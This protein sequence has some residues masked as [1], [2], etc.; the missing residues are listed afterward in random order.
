M[1]K[2]SIGFY[3]CS[4]CG[5]CQVSLLEMGNIFTDAAQ[6]AD[7]VLQ[8]LETGNDGVS[9]DSDIVDYL[10]I[11]GSIR[12]TRDREMVRMLRQKA[13]TIIAYG[14]CSSLGGLF[15][16]GNLYS[17]EELLETAYTAKST[18]AGVI[19]HG[20]SDLEDGIL[21]LPELLPYVVPL[22][23]VIAVDYILPGCPPLPNQMAKALPAIF[24]GTAG[25]KD[26]ISQ[27]SV[28]D[29]CPLERKGKKI[30]KLKPIHE[31]TLDP[32]RCL[33]EQGVL[34][35]GP[36]TAGMCE[37]VCPKAGYPCVGCNGPVRGVADQG[38]RMVTALASVITA[39]EEEQIGEAEIQE[40]MASVLDPT[41]T[42]YRF[43][44]PSSMLQYRRGE[45]N[46]R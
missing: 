31:V 9:S 3:S 41:G 45:Y 39:G 24:N 25:K 13:E 8:P 30:E 11:S 26:F 42:F 22:D 4:S 35:M 46:A 28:C 37:A 43:S 40:V 14:T 23:D 16:L 6:Q 18:D 7:I 2:K 5:G 20:E 44:L 12:N 33:L 19:P 10:F 15:G 21:E 1:N 32:D 34:C 17:A 29:V 38:A 36:A 27:K